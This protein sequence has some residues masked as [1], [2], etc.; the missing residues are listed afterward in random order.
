M[1]V[2]DFIQTNTGQLISTS[3]LSLTFLRGIISFLVNGLPVG[4]EVFDTL[5]EATNKYNF[6]V[7]QLIVPP[8]P[9]TVVGPTTVSPTTGPAATPNNFGVDGTNFFPGCFITVNGKVFPTTYGSSI[10]CSW[11][12]DGSIGA[13][14]YDLIYTGPDLQTATV[15]G[16][17]VFT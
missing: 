4:N 7:T 12:Y 9:P 13:G 17:V 8:V 14:T 5:A 1:A 6:Y 15:T 16:G 3:G 2:P 11:A 10:S